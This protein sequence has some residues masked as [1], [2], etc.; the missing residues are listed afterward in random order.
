MFKRI[1]SI[2]VLS[3]VLQATT[4]GNLSGSSK[5]DAASSK[6][7][8]VSSSY[9]ASSSIQH[10]LSKQYMTTYTDNTFKPEQA[11]TRAEAASAIARSIQTNSDTSI[12]LHFK[13]VSASH[14]YYKEIR[15]LV[16]LGVIQNSDAFHPNEP[17]KRM[18]VAKMLALAYQFKVDDKNKSKFDDV[19]RTHWA[20]NFIESLTDIGIIGGIDSKHF[21]PDKL[22]TR[23]Q[24]AVFV[25]RSIN[26][27]QKIK[28]LEVA[29]DY[30][31]KDY[32][33]T[34]NLSTAWSK[35]VIQLINVER[36]KNNLAPVVYDS[37]LT[38]IAIIK[39]QDM[40]KRNYFEHVSPYYGAPWDLATLFDYSYT[41]F[42]ENIARYINSPESV[43][44]AWM[45]S[46]NHRD[47]IM[48]EHYTNTGVAISQDS[49]GNY[50][51]VQMF[52]SQ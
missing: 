21:A 38:Q 8:D 37:K 33:P 12:S 42:G 50:Y 3:I 43:V 48:K 4:I 44:K 30:L 17:L 34:L 9:W 35:E 29:Y 22:V 36:E 7:V 40:V 52:S 31:S 20:K 24:L 14:P 27:Q 18:E 51:W 32:I 13:D 5:A 2:L 25:E 49:K 28:Q 19:T 10:M 11:I 1:I 26:F 23:A 16:D 41:S 15:K 6:A 47:N 45:L 46:P 39:A